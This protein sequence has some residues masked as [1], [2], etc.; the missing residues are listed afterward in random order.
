MHTDR[1]II[2]NILTASYECLSVLDV[3]FTPKRFFFMSANLQTELRYVT[4]GFRH[5]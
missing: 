5:D 3:H 1:L 4:S 2:D